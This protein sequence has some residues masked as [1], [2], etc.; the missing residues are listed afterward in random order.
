MVKVRRESESEAGRQSG[1]ERDNVMLGFYEQLAAM[2]PAKC[3][4]NTGVTSP[5]SAR[6]KQPH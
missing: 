1:I 5:A 4:F 2:I 3:S 6:K